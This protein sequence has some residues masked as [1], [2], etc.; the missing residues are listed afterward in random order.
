MKKTILLFAIFLSMWI[1]AQTC[2]FDQVQKELETQF[3]QIRKDREA[4]DAKLLQTDLR[5]YLDKLGA[6][7]KTVCIREPFMKSQSL[8]T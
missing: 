3:P 2:G 5:A 1:F 6:T 4:L 7:S 8:Y